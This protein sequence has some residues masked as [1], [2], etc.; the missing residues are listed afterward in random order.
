MCWKPISQHP[1]SHNSLQITNM[2]VEVHTVLALT[3]DETSTFA[4]QG[5]PTY[6]PPHGPHPPLY[7]TTPH[8]HRPRPLTFFLLFWESD[9]PGF[10]DMHFLVLITSNQYLVIICQCLV[11]CLVECKMIVA[12]LVVVSVECKLVVEGLL[13]SW[14]TSPKHVLFFQCL[15][16]RV[17]GRCNAPTK[18]P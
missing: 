15:H 8:Y 4:P 11:T 9:I 2:R 3:K 13:Y 5:L 12:V 18:N 10:F 16:F 17:I 6:T 7:S 14:C 1:D